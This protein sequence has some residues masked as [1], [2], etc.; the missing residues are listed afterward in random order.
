M[1]GKPLHDRFPDHRVELT[2]HPHRAHASLGGDTIADSTRAL[3]V[4]ETDHA[5]VIYFPREDVRMERLERTDHRTFC[6]FKGEACYWTVRAGGR[7]EVNAAWS[8]ES[9]FE[10]VA[11]L[12]GHVAYYAD[13]VQVGEDVWAFPVGRDRSKLA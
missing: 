6:P 9:P 10:P 8:Y 3:R 12:A 11:G 13:R 7:V 4:L 1:P 2:P 5:P